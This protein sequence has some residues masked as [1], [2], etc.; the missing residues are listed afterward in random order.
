MYKVLLVDDEPTIREGL[1]TLIDWEELGY[2]VADTAING[3]DAIAKCEQ[4]KPDLLIIDIRMPGMSGLDVIEHLRR[5]NH[6]LHILILSGFA[7][8]EYAKRAITFRTDGY[9]LKPVDE[10]ELI[11]YL[12]RLRKTL[13][14]KTEAQRAGGIGEWSREM[15]IQSL[16]TGGYRDMLVEAAERAGLSWQSYEVVLAKPQS[17]FNIE[18]SAVAGVKRQLIEMFDRHE[19]GA[20]FAMEPYIGIVI[21]NGLGGDANRASVLDDLRAAFGSESLDF[22]AAS[23]GAAEEWTDVERS[24]QQA[25]QVMKRRFFLS[26]DRIHDRESV[27][28]LAQKP[29]DAF[30]D[31]RIEL[32][33]LPDKIYLAIDIANDEAIRDLSRQTGERLRTAGLGEDEIKS[34]SAQLISSVIAKFAH[35]NPGLSHIAQDTSAGTLEIYKEYRY[36]EFIER[37]GELLV[38]LADSVE[39]P[40]TDKQIKKM[41]DLIQRN[42]QEN[43]KLDTLADVF[44]YNSAYLGKL[45]K[46]A[47]GEYFNTYLD[48]VRIEHAKALLDEGM[49]VYQV[50]E[51]VGYT[52]V[53]YFHSK[54]RKY[55]GTS[56]S[57]YRK[58]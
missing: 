35:A 26:N 33:D 39:T 37:M 43:L 32:D 25:L 16:L 41:I 22:V 1:R 51:K 58:K 49:K 45:F 55:V 6:S 9:L 14:L 28:L 56:P 54:F 7:D 19:R 36:D 34:H 27:T 24:Y 40:G 53:D 10:D 2:R 42:Y 47:T 38:E 18:A 46:N 23:G 15:V 21:K 5:T 44:N 20:V 31:G 48:K 13:D 8:F 52:N 50:A 17:R 57:A 11:G 12:R 3:K 30:N 4:L 29:Q